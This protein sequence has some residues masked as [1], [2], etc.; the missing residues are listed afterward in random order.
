MGAILIISL[1]VLML[2]GMPIAYA[3]VLCSGITLVSTDFADLIIMVQRMFGG[4]DSFPILACPLFI[5][6][7]YI[8][9]G[10]SMSQR[11]V[12]WASCVCGRTRGGVG[13]VTIVACAIF[14]ALTGSGP[15]TVAAIGAIMYP[16]LID[17]GYPKNSSAALVAAG[18]ALGPV[19]PPSIVMIIY[20]TTMGVSVPDMFTGAI[21]PGVLMAVAL[22]AANNL[23]ARRWGIEV[24]DKKYTAREVLGYTWKAAGTL[25]MPVLVLGG[26]YK[27]IF[28]ATE[29]AAIACAYSLLISI[30]YKSMTFKKLFEIL[31]KSATVS[32]MGLLIVG[33]ANVFGWLLAAGKIPATI[34][35]FLVPLLHTKV[36]YMAVLLI[37]LFIIGTLMETS[38]SVVIL[39]PIIVPTGLALGFDPLHLGL[40]F[41]IALVVGYITPPFGVN[42]FTVCSTTGESYVDVVKGLVPYILTVIAAVILIA[43]FPVL[44]TVLL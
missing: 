12:D 30:C 32:A 4:L 40:V 38:A 20:G 13:T 17:A 24:S 27:G 1:L 28:T 25:F 11:L 42:L 18:G 3:L 41:V 2:I 9:E 15:A 34:T 6:A 19:I 14:A 5:L 16:A 36:L 37:L 8:M 39:A 7:G 44:T 43:A 21:V 23:M 33:S 29:A 22:I 31:K 26:I 10:S 35:T